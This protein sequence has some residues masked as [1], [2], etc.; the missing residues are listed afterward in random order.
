MTSDYLDAHNR[1]M[2]DA[3][4]L[5][6]N[7]RWANADHLYGL[8]AECGLKRLMLAMGMD[9]DSTQDRP[10]NEKDRKHA[11]KIWE[12]YKRYCK[13]KLAT[14]FPLPKANPFSK[15]DVEQR[16]EHQ[17]KFDKALVESHQKAADIVSKLIKTAK[18]EGLIK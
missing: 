5:F 4:T 9:Y 2:K 8:A 6:H 1:H 18:K 12:R 14:K 15:W 3:N 17:S 16:Y 13:G 11:D 10:T 7:S